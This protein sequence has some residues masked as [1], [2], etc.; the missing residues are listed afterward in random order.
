LTGS[1]ATGEADP[2]GVIELPNLTADPTDQERATRR[3]AVYIRESTEEQGKGYSPDGQ[4]GAISQF[5]ERN[6]LRLVGEYLDLESGTKADTRKDFQR[7]IA[8]AMTGAF[9]VV[10]VFHTSRFARNAMEAKQYKK[11][12]REE[13]GV[14]V[15]SVTQAIGTDLDDP[16]AFLNESINE[17]FDEYFSRSLSFWTKMGLAQKARQGLVT[18][19]LPWG[20]SK[21]ED[22]IAVPDPER[23]PVVLT[24][25][26]IYATGSYSHRDLAHWLNERGHRTTRGNLFCADTVRDMLGNLS[27]AGFVTAQRSTSREIRGKHEPIVSEALFDRCAD[28]RRQR[29]T[30]KHPGQATSTYVLRSIVRCERCDGRMHGQK[31]GKKAEPRYYCSTRRKRGSGCDQPLA[32]AADIEAQVAEFVSQFK[33]SADIRDEILSRLAADEQWD[34]EDTTR[35]RRQLKDRRQRLRDLYE[36]GDLD[37]GEYTSKRDA[38]DAELDSLSPGATPDL[39]GARAALED[40][41]RLWEETN[42]PAERREL[43]AQLID[44]VWIDNKRIVAIRPTPTFKPYF[45]RNGHEN[46]KPLA[47]HET[48][49]RKSGSDGGQT[50]I[51]HPAGSRSGSTIHAWHTA[52]GCLREPW[53]A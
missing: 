42:D 53:A 52:H 3:A 10:L 5:A 17:V 24:L 51:A 34:D 19:S 43:V 30:T 2:A 1:F 7:L 39:D 13:L 47:S 4:R 12:L 9:D 27:Y 41:G 22:G 14:D 26:T 20:Y 25:F 32:P 31:A 44:R 6:G 16:T 29:T 11:L 21:G 23:A 50:R 45:A 40:F 8:D 18:G 15:V 37:K 36:L 49:G 33:P 28:L 48:R 35:R 38:I 46:K